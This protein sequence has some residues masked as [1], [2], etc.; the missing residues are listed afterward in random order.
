M[1]A[2]YLQVHLTHHIACT[3]I[4]SDPPTTL[5]TS[6]LPQLHCTNDHDKHTTHTHTHTQRPQTPLDSSPEIL[7]QPPTTPPTVSAT[8]TR[9]CE[10]FHAGH[11]GDQGTWR[12]V[13]KSPSADLPISSLDSV[14]TSL[15]AHAR[16]CMGMICSSERAMLKVQW[17]C[18]HESLC[19]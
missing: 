18:R 5:T 9:E 11:I 19:V 6:P 1:R 8:A 13:M 4:Q 14:F 7:P 12:A 3:Y 16:C 17:V 15:L 2:S 10:S